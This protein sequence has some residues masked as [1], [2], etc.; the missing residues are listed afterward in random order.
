[1]TASN[2]LAGI[3]GGVFIG[4]VVFIFTTLPMPG[5]PKDGQPAKGYYFEGG[6][7]VSEVEIEGCQYLIHSRCIIHKV[8]CTNH[9][10]P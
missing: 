4:V 6:N 10:K 5:P 7:W 8:T 9:P 1:M 2:I 3:A